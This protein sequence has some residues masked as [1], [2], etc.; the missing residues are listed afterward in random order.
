MAR[1]TQTYAVRLAVEG[2]GRVK[3]ELVSVGQSGEQS[4][5]RIETGGERASRGLKGRRAPGGAAAH[6]HSHTR[7]RTRWRR[8]RRGTRRTGRPL[9]LGSRC[10]RQDR[11]QDRRRR[12]AGLGKDTVVVLYLLGQENAWAL[13]IRKAGARIVSLGTRKSVLALLEDAVP[14]DPGRSAPRTS[15]D[16]HPSSSRRSP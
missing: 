7:W 2:G 4:L 9:H 5:K 1:R 16:S 15:P 14:E 12:R 13:V 8:H 11:R 10:H 3:A 6:R